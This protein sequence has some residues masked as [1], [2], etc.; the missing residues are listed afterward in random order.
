MSDSHQGAVGRNALKS[1]GS[2]GRVRHPELGQNSTFFL[3]IPT[4]HK[5][6]D[7]INIRFIQNINIY[8]HTYINSHIPIPI[9]NTNLHSQNDIHNHKTHSHIV[10][11]HI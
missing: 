7:V 8:I 3:L 9:C 11:P 2:Q 5:I 4:I 6:I 10:Q 1:N